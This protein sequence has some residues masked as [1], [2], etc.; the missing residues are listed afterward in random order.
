MRFL[1]LLFLL[2]SS[3]VNAQLSFNG[4]FEQQDYGHQIP[5][6]WYVSTGADRY[7]LSTDSLNKAQGKYSLRIEQKPGSPDTTFLLV[8]Q[9][10]NIDSFASFKIAHVSY[11]V[12]FLEG[13]KINFTPFT[14]VHEC[15]PV[16]KRNAEFKTEWDQPYADKTWWRCRHDALINDVTCSTLQ[17]GFVINYRTK[18]VVDSVTIT[19]DEKKVADIPLPPLVQYGKEVVK[20]VE[21]NSYSL[22]D[23]SFLKKTVGNAKIVALGEATHG[24]SEFFTMHNK[25]VQYL[26]DSMN[27][28]IVAFE[29]S[30][31]GTSN[32]NSVLNNY[33]S[34]KVVD[35]LF[36]RIHQVEEMAAFFDW[37][38]TSKVQLAGFD[39]QN[40]YYP[41]WLLR[42]QF[43]NVDTSISKMLD[44]LN[45]YR[46]ANKYS[47]GKTDTMY[48]MAKD[49]HQAYLKIKTDTDLGKLLTVFINALYLE[50]LTAKISLEKK[51]SIGFLNSRDSLMADNV[52]WLM[53]RYPGKK[54]IVIAHNGHIQFG[55]P[56][57]GKSKSMGQYLKK[58]YGNNF[59]SY[60]F[61]AG[62]GEATGYSNR[63]TGSTYKLQSPDPGSYEYY[64]SQ[65][66]WPS[67][68]WK[69][70][71]P[72]LPDLQWRSVGYGKGGLFQFQPIALHDNADGVFF[73]RET[74]AAKSYYLQ[75]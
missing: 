15:L 31:D 11:A 8:Y 19:L 40:F 39:N 62:N 4:N 61:L 71:S 51:S 67:F 17:V 14:A 12:K 58:M 30:Y 44:S 64:L 13:D 24:T 1:P 72:V 28:E 60:S 48:H 22:D 6:K 47:V 25:V 46:L 21:A 5:R 42:Q 3:V 55:E 41:L 74:S 54:M 75:K 45:R 52:K 18:L 7:N 27:F 36:G 10:F 23:L 50:Y 68:F 56:P 9:S 49:I 35:S 32:I 2:L 63:G 16:V 73:I 29:N 65:V 53:E 33:P 57:A 37:A 43:K 34:R 20:A 70:S 59:V 38:K 26:V 69:P 66:K